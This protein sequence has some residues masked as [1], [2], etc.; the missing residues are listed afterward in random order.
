MI[1][2]SKVYAMYLYNAHNLFQGQEAISK[3]EEVNKFRLKKKHNPYHSTHRVLYY[4]TKR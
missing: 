4:T 3:L 2:V 1:P